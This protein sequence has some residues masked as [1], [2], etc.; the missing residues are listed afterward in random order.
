LTLKDIGLSVLVLSVK[1]VG[2]F[3]RKTNRQGACRAGF[4][5]T[6]PSILRRMGKCAPAEIFHSV[7][8]PAE[9]AERRKILPGS[10]GKYF[11]FEE[12]TPRFCWKNFGEK[13][14]LA[15]T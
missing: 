5:F 9:F 1:L 10:G 15:K 14:W 11:H 12:K 3:A 7:R 4:R 6:Q 8:R 13:I 2:R